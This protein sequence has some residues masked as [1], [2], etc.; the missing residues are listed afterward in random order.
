MKTKTIFFY[1]FTIYTIG[2]YSQ[3]IK[4][5]LVSGT[6]EPMPFMDVILYALPDTLQI[7]NKV[8][9]ENG[10]FEFELNKTGEYQVV[11]YNIEENAKE[12]LNVT[13]NDTNEIKQVNLTVTSN[14]TQIKDVVIS[15]QKSL[16]KQDG[17]KT[18]VSV[19][20]TLANS[21]LTGV[22]VL[23]RMPG[24]SVDKDGKIQMKGR[25]GVM[26]MLD[27]K[28][29]YMNEE[30]LGNLLKSLPSDAIK[31][32]EIVTSP[33]AKHD[34]VGNAGIINI[35]LKQGAYEGLTGSYNLS[36]GYGIYHKSN[37]G[38][39]MSYKKKKWSIDGG[40][41][42]NNNEGLA[43]YFTHRKYDNPEN[44]LSQFNTDGYFRLPEKS[45]S[46]NLRTQYKV[47][48]K[49][50]FGFN[51]NAMRSMFEWRGGTKS[52]W[53]KTDNLD[54]DRYEGDDNGYARNL[55]LNTG[56]DY[57]YKF[58]TL[59]T[60]LNMGVST[61]QGS[62]KIEKDLNIFYFDT[63]QSNHTY[64][65]KQTNN[66]R[67][68]QISSKVD[69]EKTIFKK[70]K[71]ETG[72]KYNFLKDYRPID[73]TI[74]EN[75]SLSDASNHF[76]YKEEVAAA[77]LMGNSKVNKWKFQGG[78][79][80]ENTNVAGTLT[81][82]DTTFYRN[83]LNLFPSASI[84]Y[85]YSEATSFSFVYSRR[86]RR[87]S[88]QDLNPVLNI[89]DPN[90]VW[91]G[92]PYLL[93]ELTHNTELNYSMLAGYL[94]ATVNYSKTMNPILWVSKT[95]PKTLF[96]ESGNRNLTSSSNRGVAVSTNFP[97]TKWWNTNNYIYVYQNQY[98]GDLG[99]GYKINK[100]TSFMFNSTQSFKLPKRFSFEI[101]GNYEGA[102]AYA[103]GRGYPFGQVNVAIQKKMFNDKINL[104]IAYSDIFWTMRY[105]GIT[106]FNSVT[107]EG[108]YTWD[109]RVFM[110]TFNYKFGK[111]VVLN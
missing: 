51:V 42:Y 67:T 63:L 107:N 104:K 81:L 4:G 84:T 109:N 26:V 106:K 73:V 85:N 52:G 59:G 16:V 97:I 71:I 70:V 90:T 108:G 33:S 12:F 76:L 30:Q 79:R 5:M 65:L 32:I 91:G 96:T 55:N 46:L 93:P 47:N 92:D 111:R 100:Q 64:Y 101:S 18:I 105:N 72:A 25:G 87:P 2:V 83:Y 99:V 44:N 98:E 80:L 48:A 10:Q 3:Q 88:G 49:S 94:I 110:V 7:A 35:R 53:K 11:A 103:L 78:L 62:S 13:I 60:K 61:N 6:G 82:K 21:G 66:P 24:I 75:D 27:D 1:F 19:E 56:I 69:F 29:L 39:S 31:E 102:K 15:S 34:A 23:R 41:Q 74:N 36:L 57:Q 77:Y 40:Y 95:N 20:N 50:N 8:S 38:I 45:H 68:S 89:N 86:I 28:A 22:D 58:D 17:E 14:V 37:T 9:N 54:G 43:K